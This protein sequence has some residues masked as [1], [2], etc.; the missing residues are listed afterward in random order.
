MGL[1]VDGGLGFK[2]V[3]ADPSTPRLSCAA[4]GTFSELSGYSFFTPLCE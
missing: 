2:K 1:W 4:T 3:L